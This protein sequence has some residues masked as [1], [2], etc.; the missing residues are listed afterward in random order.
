MS[1]SPRFFNNQDGSPNYNYR[2]CSFPS[3]QWQAQYISG[4][5][6]REHDFWIGLNR[7]TSLA[8]ATRQVAAAITRSATRPS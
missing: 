2:L 3:G 4:P 6:T 7:P 1:R 8:E 5:G